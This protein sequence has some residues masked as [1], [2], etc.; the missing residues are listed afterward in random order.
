MGNL[1][2]FAYHIIYELEHFVFCCS[3]STLDRQSVQLLICFNRQ[4]TLDISVAHEPNRLCVYMQMKNTQFPTFDFFMLMSNQS[5]AMLVEIS[6]I[7]MNLCLF[8]SVLRF[9]IRFSFVYVNPKSQSKSLAE[10][11]V[12][13]KKKPNHF[14]NVTVKIVLFERVIVIRN[15]VFLLTNAIYLP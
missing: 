3:N 6:P 9:D 14:A 10:S 8:Y 2:E 11:I 15:S 12:N 4:P 7:S 5:H 13:N 1:S